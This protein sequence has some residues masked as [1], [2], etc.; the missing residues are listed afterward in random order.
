MSFA[1]PLLLLLLLAIPAALAARWMLRRR[2]RRYAVRF[3]ALATLASAIP[4]VPAW[5]REL[6]LGLFC[7]ALAA[8]AL[9]A[10]R[11][12]REVDV[13]LE[14]ATIVLVSDASRSMLA[15]D[16]E[17]SRM[18]AARAAAQLFLDQVPDGV[19]VG[20]VGFSDSPHTIEPPTTDHDEIRDF[21][22]ELEADGGTAT[23]DAL[24]VALGLLERGRRD[25]EDG[26]PGA[27][28][29]LSDGKH[30]LG[31][32]PTEVARQARRARVPIYT[33]ALGT[34]VGIVDT[35]AGPV[36]VPPDP[37]TMRAIARA[38]GGRAFVADEADE[39]E[40]VYEDLG[41][42]VATRK[43]TREVTALFAGGGL[44]LLIGALG[45]GLR[46]AGRLP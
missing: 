1:A 41:S 13:P 46:G 42:R 2:A 37:E 18:A 38:S 7:A 43:E 19:R 44:V 16:V 11:P 33:V 25:A 27:I 22:D 23:G 32:D 30:T 3:P 24:A 5:R 12:E 29:L 40:T 36:A 34:D 28:V 8:L 20:G 21:V 6:P 14:Q 9:A 45:L 17:P 15:D 39:L 4:P 31:R 10:A 26:A 35:P